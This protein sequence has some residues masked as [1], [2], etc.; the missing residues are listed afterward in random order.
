MCS[1]SQSPFHTVVLEPE[2][3]GNREYNGVS[4]VANNTIIFNQRYIMEAYVQYMYLY[5]CY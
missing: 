3:V 2:L 1:Y 5:G 4:H